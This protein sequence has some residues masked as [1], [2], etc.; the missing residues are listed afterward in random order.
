[1]LGVYFSGRSLFTNI[2]VTTVIFRFTIRII[3][4]NFSFEF[5]I[6]ID[7]FLFVAFK[8]LFIFI[9]FLICPFFVSHVLFLLLI[10]SKFDVKELGMGLEQ[11]V[12][13]FC[14]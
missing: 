9:I 5:F 10:E 1:M 3:A 13:D 14:I 8:I 7:N 4:T 11:V 6:I 12:K 2:V